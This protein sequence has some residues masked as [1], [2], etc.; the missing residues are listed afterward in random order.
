MKKQK[1]IKILKSTDIVD[2]QILKG[3]GKS[4]YNTE[5]IINLLKKQKFDIVLFDF[6]L[7]VKDSL[8]LLKNL[9]ISDIKTKMIIFTCYGKNNDS[10]LIRKN[11][12]PFSLIIEKIPKDFVKKI[13]SLSKDQEIKKSEKHLLLIA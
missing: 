9:K 8:S 6:K 12:K 2:N 10:F 13:K 11:E 3:V 1:N 4:L 7:R 5:E